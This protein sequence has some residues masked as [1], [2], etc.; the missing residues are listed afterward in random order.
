M[1]RKEKIDRLSEFCGTDGSCAEC[2]L[3]IHSGVFCADKEWEEYTDREL[4]ECLRKIEGPDPVNKAAHYQLP[5]GLECWDVMVACFGEEEV[6]IWAKINAFTY[7]FQHKRKNG[8][9]DIR[10]A[11][12]NLQK[13]FNL[14]GEAE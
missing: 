2:R 14:G 11:L 3:Q 12:V 4:D 1:T 13:Y 10:K 8:D 6:K 7:L 5:G 9:E